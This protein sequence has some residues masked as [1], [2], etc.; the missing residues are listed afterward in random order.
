MKRAGLVIIAATLLASGCTHTYYMPRERLAEPSSWQFYSAD[1]QAT[2]ADTDSEYSG[3]L[4]VIW[5][6]KT[7]D[8]P[9]GPLTIAANGNLVYAGARHRI[10]F[11]D[12]VTGSFKGRIKTKK[13]PQTG[14][15]VTD[16][17]GYFATAPKDN[18]L[19]CRN[20]YT[21]HEVWERPVKDAVFGTI[22]VNDR[23]IVGSGDGAIAAL[24]QRTGETAWIYRSESRFTAPPSAADGRVF[25]PANDGRL[26]GLALADGQELFVAELEAPLVNAAAVADLVYVGD[27]RG[28]VYA[29]DPADGRVVWKKSI[30]GPI[31]TSPAV[32]YGTVF[33]GHSGGELVALD[34]ATGGTKWSYNAIDVI[35][36]SPIVSGQYVVVGTL[37]G[38]LYVF[39]A[40]NGNLKANREIE[41]SLSIGPVTDGQHVYIATDAGRIFCFGKLEQTI[42][43]SD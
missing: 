7:N 6:T 22:I 8:K 9:T 35:R 34:A 24:D 37:S 4:D 12:L 36:A 30:G 43:Q 33:V 38:K 13:S 28:N 11:F 18:S 31:W 10:K 14:M 40:V 17:L 16:S 21:G 15:L 20:L 25:Q 1:V 29:L 19:I 27:V 5:E 41:G 26:Y 23:L 2:G 32:A 39:D 3:N 42:S